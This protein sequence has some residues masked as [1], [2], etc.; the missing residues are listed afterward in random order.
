MTLLFWPKKP[1]Q[2]RNASCL[3]TGRHS[4]SWKQERAQ[5]KHQVA[6]VK[7]CNPRDDA[8]RH[9]PS[10]GPPQG[11]DSSTFQGFASGRRHSPPRAGALTEPC[12]GPEARPQGGDRPQRAALVAGTPGS[13]PHTPCRPRRGAPTGGGLLTGGTYLSGG[14]QAAPEGKNY[15]SRHAPSRARHAGSGSARHPPRSRPR[16]P[17]RRRRHRRSQAAPPPRYPHPSPPVAPPPRGAPPA[18]RGSPLPRCRF[19]HRRLPPCCP[20]AARRSEPLA[21][22]PPAP[23]GWG[24]GGGEPAGTHA[25]GERAPGLPSGA[26]W[27]RGGR[28]PLVRRRGGPRGTSLKGLKRA[29]P[30]ALFP[31]RAPTRGALGLPTEQSLWQPQQCLEWGQGHYHPQ[32]VTATSPFPIFGVQHG[33]KGLGKP[34]EPRPGQWRTP[35]CLSRAVAV[36]LRPRKPMFLP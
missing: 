33:H 27:R 14:P 25:H 31:P 12:R 28:G 15:S 8:H 21:R 30:T 5:T 6:E 2:N 4:P 24:G 22:T 9:T 34:T 11:P 19:P 26:P 35:R 7:I 17:W 16:A 32:P 20:A 18:P 10:N 1:P 3:R 29:R 36:T 13:G 23:A